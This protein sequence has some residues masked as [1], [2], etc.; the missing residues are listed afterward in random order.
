[1]KLARIFESVPGKSYPAVLVI[2]AI[3][4]PLQGLSNFLVYYLPQR[5][6]HVEF[7][8]NAVS[9]AFSIVF[10][11]HHQPN[12]SDGLGP[13]SDGESNGI[14]ADEDVDDGSVSILGAPPLPKTS[15]DSLTRPKASELLKEYLASQPLSPQKKNLRRETTRNATGFAASFLRV[16]ENE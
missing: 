8:I 2:G 4:V 3:C 7:F 9:S 11:T 5:E 1:M 6:K 14:E 15:S 13:F 16:L 12:S 10:T